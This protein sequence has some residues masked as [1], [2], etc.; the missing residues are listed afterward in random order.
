MLSLSLR[1]KCLRLKLSSV[2]LDLQ[3]RFQ[4]KFGLRDVTWSSYF[5]GPLPIFGI[6]RTKR[7]SS[8]KIAGEGTTEESFRD[9]IAKRKS[10]VDCFT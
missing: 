9:Y 10:L 1:K 7:Q 6:A 3:E 4:K 2:Y 8:G 5:E